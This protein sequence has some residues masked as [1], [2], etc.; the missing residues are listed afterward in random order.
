VVNWLRAAAILAQIDPVQAGYLTLD[1]Q[2]N[3]RLPVLRKLGDIDLLGAGQM[4]LLAEYT[5]H[6]LSDA[7]F[8]YS[9]PAV[10]EAQVILQTLASRYGYDPTNASVYNNKYRN[11]ALSFLTGERVLMLYSSQGLAGVQAALDKLRTAGV[12]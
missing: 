12:I 6:N 11:P 4:N 1:A 8:T 5:L 3:L 9:G 2:G 7:D 10:S